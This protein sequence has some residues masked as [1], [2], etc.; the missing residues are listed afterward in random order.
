MGL[1]KHTGPAPQLWH[2]FFILGPIP[3][4]AIRGARATTLLTYLSVGWSDVAQQQFA[5]LCCQESVTMPEA[6]CST[7]S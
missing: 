5:R 2:G 4:Y 7:W 1:F 3:S 6:A